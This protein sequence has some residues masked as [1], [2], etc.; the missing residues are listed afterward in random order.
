MEEWMTPMD[1][2]RTGDAMREADHLMLMTIQ[3]TVERLEKMVESMQDRLIRIES[4]V[5]GRG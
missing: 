5:R 1:F 4:A 3:A 2:Q